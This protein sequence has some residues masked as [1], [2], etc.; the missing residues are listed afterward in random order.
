MNVVAPK[1]VDVQFDAF[2]EEFVKAINKTGA[3]WIDRGQFSAYVEMD[4][5]RQLGANMLASGPV[6]MQA[7]VVDYNVPVHDKLTLPPESAIDCTPERDCTPTKD[8]NQ[9]MDCAQKAACGEVCTVRLFGHCVTHGHD[10]GCEAGKLTRKAGCELEKKRRQGQCEADKVANKASCEVL[11]K[12]EKDTCEGLKQ[13]Y[14]SV[15]GTGPDYGNVSSD[16]IQLNGSARVCLNDIVLESK[17]LRLTAKF[18]AEGAATARGKITFTPLNVVGHVMCFSGFDYNLAK[19]M[20]VTPQAIDVDTEAQ[21]QGD[22]D[23]VAIGVRITN[24]IHIEFPFRGIAAELAG[25]PKF[26]IECPIPGVATKLRVLTPDQWWPKVARGDIDKDFPGFDFRLDLFKKPIDAGG[27]PLTGKLQRTSQ[28]VG[29]VFYIS[30][31]ATSP[32]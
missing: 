2:R 3:T 25:D 18:Q 22:A 32:H 30:P 14:K 21:F 1:P 20:R 9:T 28:G 31:G 26:Q 17:T 24:P 19:T 7:K 11:K 4:V 23:T 12:G 6:C 29:G 8:C 5:V 10:A 13:A 16:G 15:R 27:V